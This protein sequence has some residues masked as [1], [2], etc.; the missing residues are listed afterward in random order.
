MRFEELEK[1]YRMEDRYWWFVSRRRMIRALIA[2]WGPPSPRV[3][4]VGCGTG[5]GMDS[6]ADIATVAGVDLSDD[7]LQFCRLRGHSFLNRCRAEAIAFADDSFDVAVCCDVIE[8]L[9]DD[10]AGLAEVLRILRPGGIAVIT[11]PAYKWLWSEH[12]EA[13]SHRRRYERRE[14]HDKLK[15]HGVEV[16]KLTFA[17]SFVLPIVLGTRLLGRLRIR[18]LGKPHTQ[19]MALPGWLNRLFLWLGDIENWV[20]TWG[21]FPC[22]ASL[23]AV[24]RKQDQR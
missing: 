3:V 14:L 16:V 18:K 22:G 9:E 13:L 15:V 8:H 7:A 10:Q 21:G 24:V 19:T 4:D 20:L 1:M 12:D 17:V 5:G 11:V 23:V 6:L 2:R